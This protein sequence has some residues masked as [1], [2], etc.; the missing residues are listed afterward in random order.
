LYWANVDGML[1][2]WQQSFGCHVTVASTDALLPSKLAQL[3]SGR[4]VAAGAEGGGDEGA[5]QRQSTGLGQHGYLAASQQQQRG[6]AVQPPAAVFVSSPPSTANAAAAFTGS[7]AANQ[8]ARE[9]AQQLVHLLQQQWQQ[10]LQAMGC[11]AAAASRSWRLPPVL[12]CKTP[13]RHTAVHLSGSADYLLELAQQ[14]YSYNANISHA[15]L[16]QH[17]RYTGAVHINSADLAAAVS[18]NSSAGSSSDSAMADA[19]SIVRM[20]DTIDVL[21]LDVQRPTGTAA[22]R[23]GWSTLYNLLYQLHGFVGFTREL[24]PD[25]RTRLGWFRRPDR[26]ARSACHTEQS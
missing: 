13:Q 17:G 22:H 4:A 1:S 10:Q 19:G 11:G 18:S 20:L 15:E 23:Q 9:G 25:G 2:M 8:Q 12:S 5:M 21:L 16:E 6:G 24:L 7:T 3:S 14:I 26:L